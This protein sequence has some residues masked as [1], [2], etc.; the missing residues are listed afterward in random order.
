MFAYGSPTASLLGELY[1]STDRGIAYVANFVDLRSGEKK[2]FSEIRLCLY[3]H[4]RVGASTSSVSPSQCTCQSIIL[5][6]VLIADR[7]PCR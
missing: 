2:R 4:V 5:D 6:R 7:R 1:R 3:V